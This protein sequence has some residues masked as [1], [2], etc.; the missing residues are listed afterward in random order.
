MA[1]RGA[2][3][4]GRPARGTAGTARRRRRPPRPRPGSKATSDAWG[5]PFG[6]AGP[7]RPRLVAGGRAEGAAVTEA[8]RLACTDPGKMVR[9]LRGKASDRKLRLFVVSCCRG[10]WPGLSGCP[11]P[12]A[13]E[14]AERFADGLAPR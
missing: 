12:A 7:G 2:G 4:P 11:N 13:V 8:Q 14:I 6:W 5:T 3:C 10:L 9:H 1:R